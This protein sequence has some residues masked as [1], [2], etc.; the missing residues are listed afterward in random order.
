MA[1]RINND[2][3]IDNGK[4]II[5]AGIT[6]TGSLYASGNVGTAGS[7]LSSTGAGIEWIES[8]GGINIVDLSTAATYY[9]LFAD[10]TSGKVLNAF[11]SS[12]NL[13]FNPSTGNFSAVQL[14]TLSDR[15]QKTNIKVVENPVELTKQLE[16]VTFDWVHTDQP[17]MGV[18]AQDVE[19]VLPELVETGEDGLKRVN[20]SGMIGLLIET[21]KE[22]QVRIEELE[23][24]INV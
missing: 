20:Y 10:A 4:N 16:G 19:K 7:V 14:T 3:V 12:T 18:I 11:I 13:T 17:S 24:K 15:T 2:V 22:Q 1:I 6:I 9:P 5:G 23:K 8:P 21:I